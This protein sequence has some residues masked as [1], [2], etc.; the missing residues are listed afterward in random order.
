MTKNFTTPEFAKVLKE[1]GIEIDT[2]YTHQDGNVYAYCLFQ[3]YYEMVNVTVDH[4]K[5][6][7]TLHVYAA[8]HEIVIYPTYPLTEVLGW[9]PK[10]VTYKDR[11]CDI[12]PSLWNWA[13]ELGLGQIEEYTFVLKYYLDEMPIEQLI[14]QGLTEGWLTKETI[15][16]AIKDN[17]K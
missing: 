7:K 16:Q 5:A 13:I 11:T 14:T 6:T 15:L 8:K 4:T 2:P 17:A 9:L 10:T 3:G 12:V 1:H